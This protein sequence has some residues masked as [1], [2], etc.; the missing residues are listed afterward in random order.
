MRQ[1]EQPFEFS[2]LTFTFRGN[3]LP[4]LNKRAIDGN[5]VG[6]VWLDISIDVSVVGWLLLVLFW[7]CLVE[8]GFGFPFARLRAAV[9]HIRLLVASFA[10]RLV[11][12]LLWLFVL[13]LFCWTNDEEEKGI[14]R[15]KWGR[16]RPKPITTA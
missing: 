10:R 5:T 4:E 9:C 8:F 2:V 15:T 13:V 6:C 12:L 7:F 14:R 16:E 3:V 1:T 11:R